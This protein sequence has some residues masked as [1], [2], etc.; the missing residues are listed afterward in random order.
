MIELNFNVDGNFDNA[1]KSAKT[2]SAEIDSLVNKDRTMKVEA[3][4]KS[5]KQS[6]SDLNNEVQK[7]QSRKITLDVNAN[8]IAKKIND[9]NKNLESL[10]KTKHKIQV[11]LSQADKDITDFKKQI[12]AILEK[13]AKL[14]INT[15]DA[16]AQI[17][18]I[19]AQLNLIQD[20]KIKLEAD[21]GNSETEIK[22]FQNLLSDLNDK[23]LKIEVDLQADNLEQVNKDIDSLEDKKISVN[24]DLQTEGFADIKAKFDAIGE[25]GA[26]FSELSADGLELA[27]TMKQV[28]AQTGLTGKELDNLQQSAVGAFRQGLGENVSE[29]V[30]SIAL[31]RQV[32]GEFLDT[33]E[34]DK[35]VVGAGAIAKT[36][37][38]DINEV[39]SGSRTFIANFGLDGQKAFE[40][41]G[42]AIQ[43]TGSKMDDTLDTLDEYSQLVK[44]AGFNAEEFVGIITS[45]MQAGVRDTDKLAA[46][47]G[48]GPGDLDDAAAAEHLE[49][50][51]GIHNSDRIRAGRVLTVHG[52]SH[53]A[54]ACEQKRHGLAGLEFAQA[55]LRRGQDSE[56]RSIQHRDAARRAGRGIAGLIIHCHARIAG[57]KRIGRGVVGHHIIAPQ[58]GNGAEHTV[59]VN[60]EIRSAAR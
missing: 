9:V 39:I 43:Q 7:I 44:S 21:I 36:F 2:A 38:K 58:G 59:A 54:V 18:E 17:S 40:L 1:L 30:K 25:I 4:T 28:S 57:V 45:G 34:I 8:E 48:I 53:A 41:V 52:A 56:L 55:L 6:V 33:K 5:A 19:K 35:F 32:L 27:D 29:A 46:V 47:F 13:E 50:A 15:S 12:N 42:Y 16:E 31:G 37:D 24:V 26:K 20:K 23:K 10:E 11:D 14:E 49:L 60:I 3:D 51:V 22:Q